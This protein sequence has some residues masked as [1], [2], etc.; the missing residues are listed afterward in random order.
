M[1]ALIALFLFT[2]TN[3]IASDHTKHC[4]EI[5]AVI[6]DAVRRGDLTHREAGQLIGRCTDELFE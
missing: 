4:D 3:A 6:Q 5:A 2:S 1:Y